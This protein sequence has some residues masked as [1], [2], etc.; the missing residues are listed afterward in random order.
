MNAN[1]SDINRRVLVID[2]NPAIHRDFKKILGGAADASHHA[3]LDSLESSIFGDKAAA[4]MTV[5]RIAFEIDSAYQ[6]DEGLSMVRRATAEG[7]PYAMAFV[8]VRMPPGWNG[9]ETVARIWCDHPD[10][11]VVICTAFSDFSWDEIIHR[12]SRRDSLLILK[13]PFDN[14]EV[15]QFAAAL[16]EKWRLARDARLRLDDLERRVAERTN[17]IQKNNDDLVALTRELTAARDAAEAA[18]EVKARFLANVSHEIRTPLTAILGYADVLLEQDDPSDQRMDCVRTIRRHGDNLLQIINDILD[19]SKIDAG[20]L[21]IEQISFSP[22]AMAHDV[23]S[24]MDVR[25][26]QA[27]IGLVAETV[28]PIPAAIRGDPTRLRQILVNLV[29]N[30]IKFTKAGQVRVVTRLTRTGDEGTIEFAV[31]DT[32]IGIE[33]DALSRLFQPFTQA[34]ESTT[35][36]FGGTG[37]GLAISRKLA[38]ALGGDVTVESRPGK[39][40]IFRATVRTGP[41]TDAPM[42]EPGDPA[43]AATATAVAGTP[44]F[45]RQLVGRVLL[46]EDCLDNQRLIR[47]FLTTAGLD[48]D[49]AADGLSAIEKAATNTYD[50]ILMDMSMP[51]IDGYEATRRLRAAGYDRPIVA[52]TAHAMS[53]DRRECLDAG[54]DE[55]ATKPIDR[56]TLL[57]TVARFLHAPDDHAA[58]T[59]EPV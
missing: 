41:L 46:V 55:H 1:E 44:V 38:Q 11:Q 29:G 19:L 37:L 35:R 47:H 7:R 48:V 53:T 25:A 15:L 40:S 6:G 12:L 14:M 3:D 5:P 49:T 33:P 28:G 8:D 52:L 36:Q 54:C 31:H 32:G 51:G 22:H 21:T 17:V 2:D 26:K 10:L 4:T 27:G 39:G 24:L 18:N 56:V 9:I 59:A 43:V 23:I 16:T 50:V 30:A 13:K 42:I 57:E 58:A 34:N 45:D 20:R